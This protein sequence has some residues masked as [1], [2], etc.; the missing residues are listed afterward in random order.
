MCFQHQ[1]SGGNIE[2][3]NVEN[4]FQDGCKAQRMVFN[5]SRETRGGLDPRF[6]NHRQDQS[7]ASIIANQMGL[8]IHDPNDILQFDLTLIVKL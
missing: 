3:P 2:N 4:L 1:R 5:G 7:P 6:Y 8:Y